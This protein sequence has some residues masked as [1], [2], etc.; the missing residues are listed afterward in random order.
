MAGVLKAKVGGQWVPI[1]GSG[2]SAETARWNS[3]WGVIATETT[4]LT[5]TDGTSVTAG[6]V[7]GGVS[8]LTLLSGTRYRFILQIRAMETATTGT[9]LANLFKNAAAMTPSQQGWF[10]CQNSYESTVWSYNVNGDGSTANYTIVAGSNSGATL[11]V[12]LSGPPGNLITVEDVGPVIYSAAPAP[13]NTPTPWTAPTFLNGWTNLSTL[14]PAAYRSI[15]DMVQ[16][17]GVITRST[18]PGGVGTRSTVFTLPVGFRPP[19]GY[20]FGANT[21]GAAYGDT[22][23]RVDVD[24]TG[25]VSLWVG[26]TAQ[27]IH[28]YTSLGTIQFSTT[29]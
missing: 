19:I 2:M 27:N 28:A 12:H 22:Q 6:L 25:D 29:L 10:Q 9:F 14:T 11:K 1:I 13:V 8:N 18:S 5:I 4:A 3:A 23:C 21:S 16:V 24:A 15:G 7:L 20:I 17:R 26:S